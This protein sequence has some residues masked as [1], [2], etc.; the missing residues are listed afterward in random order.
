MNPDFVCLFWWK[1]PLF[2]SLLHLDL[3]TLVL[4]HLCVLAGPAAPPEAEPAGHREALWGRETTSGTP[5]CK[6]CLYLEE[7]NHS[8]LFLF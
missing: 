8:V 6:Q 3:V 4:D 1:R 7:C 2:A 5:L